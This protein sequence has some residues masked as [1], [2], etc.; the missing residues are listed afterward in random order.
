MTPGEL[1][2]QAWLLYQK[3][4]D[5]DLDRERRNQD[6]R[7]RKDFEL[8]SGYSGR[9]NIRRKTRLYLLSQR[10]YKRYKRRLEACL[11]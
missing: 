9:R 10:A 4:I 7:N 11:R 2:T 8:T 5:L 6:R 3:L 1:A